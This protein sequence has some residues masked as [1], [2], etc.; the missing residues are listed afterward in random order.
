MTGKAKA[1][2]QKADDAVEVSAQKVK[3]TLR[4][5]A[6]AAKS[7]ADTLMGRRSEE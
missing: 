6:G 7:A 1:V 5:A 2:V 4:T 3:G